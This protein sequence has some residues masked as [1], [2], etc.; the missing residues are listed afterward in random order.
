MSEN[1][2]NRELLNSESNQR[3]QKFKDLLSVEAIKNHDNNS[4]SENLHLIGKLINES[5]VLY[6]QGSHLQTNHVKSS[7]EMVLDAQV[8]NIKFSYSL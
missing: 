4:T 2:G 5:N 3:K 1:S 8:G 7:S 6:K